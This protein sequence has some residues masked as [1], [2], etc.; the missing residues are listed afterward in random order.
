MATLCYNTGQTHFN[1]SRGLIVSQL[2]RNI[3]ALIQQ[4]KLSIENAR[5]VPEIG[6]A[7]AVLGI[8]A[9]RIQAGA[10]LLATAESRQAEQVRQYS[11]QYAATTALRQAWA[12]AT[13]TYMLHRKLARLALSDEPDLQKSLLL[14]DK[15]KQGL[16]A[17]LGQAGVFYHNALDNDA[18]LTAL[19]R[20]NLTPELLA[21][22]ATA[23]AEVADLQAAQERQKAAAQQATKQRNAALDALDVWYMEFRTVARLALS[24]DEQWLEALGL[25]AV[26]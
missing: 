11:Q 4:A 14:H 22:G 15:R 5:S 19:G 9:A 21:Q 16:D 23:V 2:R 12:A 8:D 7:L 10:D 20:F 24:E 6:A 17:W 25:G 13:K 18:V 1:N 26:A 3:N